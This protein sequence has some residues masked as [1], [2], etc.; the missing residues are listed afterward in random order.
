MC[1]SLAEITVGGSVAGISADSFVGCTGI[2]LLNIDENQINEPGLLG[3]TLLERSIFENLQHNIIKSL[4]LAGANVNERVVGDADT[5]EFGQQM[6]E[7]A[8]E[9]EAVKKAE[10]LNHYQKRI[11]PLI[12]AIAIRKTAPCPESPA[13]TCMP[14]KLLQDIFFRLK[15]LFGDYKRITQKDLNHLRNEIFGSADMSDEIKLACESS[16]HCSV[17]G[18]SQS[19]PVLNFLSQYAQLQLEHARLDDWKREG[20]SLAMVPYKP[21]I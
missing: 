7:W 3:L 9:Y 20:G 11:Q 6:I 21:N 19:S 15:Y 16:N 1:T 2:N 18:N 17:L 13:V 8:G 10:E 5:P 12:N 14:E 4:I